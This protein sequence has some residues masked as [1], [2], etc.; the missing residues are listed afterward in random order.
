VE[1]VDLADV[2]AAIELIAGFALAL[3]PGLELSR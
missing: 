1:M 2:D 3:T